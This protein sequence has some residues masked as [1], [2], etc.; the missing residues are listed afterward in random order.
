MEADVR[1][2]GGGWGGTSS[3][4]SMGYSF[5][6]LLPLLLPVLAGVGG[7]IPVNYGGGCP[8]MCSGRGV[9]AL[10]SESCLCDEGFSGFD[11]SV[12]VC[13]SG[14]AW[15][16]R[17]TANEVAHAPFTECSAMGVCNRELGMCECREGYTGE[18]CER[19]TCP[20]L[21]NCNG[22]GRCVTMAE[23]AEQIDG[24]SLFRS[25][26]Y[27]VWDANLVHG[28]ICDAGYQGYDCSER[29]C[30]TGF[31]PL[32]DAGVDEVVLV[33]CTCPTTCSGSVVLQ[34]MGFTTA[35]I[36]HDA[37]RELLKARIEALPVVKEVDIDFPN[38]AD[39]SLCDDSGAT[40][41]I[42]FTRQP[43][44]LDSVSVLSSLISSGGTPSVAVF[45]KG[46]FSVLNTGFSSVDGTKTP[47]TCSGR[48]SCD[49]S[50]GLCTCFSK[51]LSSDGKGGAGTLP[52]CGYFDPS[53]PPTACPDAGSGTC[54][55]SG[56]CNSSPSALS[57][58]CNSGFGGFACELQ[59]CLTGRSWFD[60]ASGGAAHS[61]GAECSNG[62]TCDTSSGSCT[63]WEGVFSG[64][65]CE[66]MECANSCNDHGE[67][68]SMSQ[69]AAAS[70]STLGVPEIYT[71]TEWDADMVRTCACNATRAVDNFYTGE[72]DTFRGPQAYADSSWKAYD[73]SRAKCATG[74]DWRTSGQDNEIQQVTCT[75]ELGSFQLSFRGSLSEEIAFNANLAG[76]Q[77][78]LESTAWIDQLSVTFL[79]GATTAC[80]SSGSTAFT[81]EFLT[82][83]GPLPLL[84]E[85]YTSLKMSDG[86]TPGSVSVLGVQSSTK[87]D[88]EC[89][90]HGVCDELTGRCSCSAGYQSSDGAGNMGERGDCAYRSELQTSLYSGESFLDGSTASENFY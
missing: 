81:V 73:C 40:T 8:N 1:R 26:S 54:S 13:P 76:V 30:L 19:R 56:A 21:G 20:G 15:A 88:I 28:C 12:R 83:H 57:C 22:H 79:S 60:E 78:A 75:G 17:A 49:V 50:T 63:C 70:N 33:D 53:D 47:L 10:E 58:T 38:V 66:L 77:S 71:Y 51:F 6:S 16:D 64:D 67:C 89:A 41:S 3:G 7:A 4:S 37:T 5:S 11:C 87:E 59:T 29:E 42:T 9:C 55:G 36:P 90:G 18:A 65:A 43:G 25:D 85:D 31:D 44:S 23:A 72:S 74:D 39:A 32:T 24:Y 68:A 34:F 52:D 86:V 61:L 82:E 45:E 2:A 46:D 80:S 35:S 62:G 69:L 27:S 14:L 48:G 84:V